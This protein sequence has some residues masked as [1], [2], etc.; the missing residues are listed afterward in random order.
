MRAAVGVK[1][2]E[3]QGTS[4][5]ALDNCFCNGGD[6][7]SHFSSSLPAMEI[8]NDNRHNASMAMPSKAANLSRKIFFVLWKSNRSRLCFQRIC[9]EPSPISKL[10]P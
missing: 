4:G 3:Y 5:S 7:L 2:T 9:T 10:V 1:L 8:S 6:A